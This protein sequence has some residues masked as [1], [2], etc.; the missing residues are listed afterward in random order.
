MKILVLSDSHGCFKNMESA[1]KKER[2]DMVF[3]L[4]DTVR[5]A[6][7][8]QYAYP[9]LPVRNVCGNCDYSY[10][11]DK[12]LNFELDGVRF[13]LTHGHLF[14][15]KSSY[16]RVVS[17]AKKANADMLLFGHTH[18][19]L[20]SFDESLKIMNPGSCSAYSRATYGIIWLE[21]R[22]LTFYTIKL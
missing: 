2:P 5:D 17:A 15:V 16:L 11:A 9:E 6:D 10:G 3:H 7:D 4:G 8:I 18:Q 19:A 13:Y 12:V 22:G 1:I 21:N 20:C 14:G